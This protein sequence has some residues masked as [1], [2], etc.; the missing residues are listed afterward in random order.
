MRKLSVWLVRV[1]EGSRFGSA[2]LVI[3]P[4]FAFAKDIIGVPGAFAWP[5]AIASFAVG[6]VQLGRDNGFGFWMWR[7]LQ[8]RYRELDEYL[9]RI[10][11][12]KDFLESFLAL[13][14][15]TISIDAPEFVKSAGPIVARL[16]LCGDDQELH[17]VGAVMNVAAFSGSRYQAK[18]EEK[19]VRNLSIGQRHP[20]AI[21]IFGNDDCANG[22][23]G[24][25]GLIPIHRN[26]EAVYVTAQLSDNDLTGV[27]VAPVGTKSTMLVAFMIANAPVR[28]GKAQKGKPNLL[29]Y[30]NLIKCGIL[31]MILICGLSKDDDEVL[32]VAANASPRLQALFGWLKLKPR[33][34]FKS[35]DD[36]PMYAAPIKIVRSTA[37]ARLI[38]RRNRQVASVFPQL[39]A[40]FRR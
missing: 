26:A 1:F 8:P 11:K 6:M 36:A 21:V 31:Q 38:A 33:P 24:L 27:H 37:G 35:A 13:D 16:K 10:D 7:F 22:Y 12:D 18:A 5:L 17:H 4:V 40:R 23:D 25:S 30:G 15:G 32:L 20:A 29:T 39:R 28:D 14:D 34:D 3:A 19:F 9:R 2:L